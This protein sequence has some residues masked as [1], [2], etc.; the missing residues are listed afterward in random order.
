[1][2]QLVNLPVSAVIPPSFSCRVYWRTKHKNKKKSGCL[3]GGGAAALIDQWDDGR[4]VIAPVRRIIRRI[5][6]R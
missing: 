5:T 1:M 4:G 3:Y 2:H 6:R